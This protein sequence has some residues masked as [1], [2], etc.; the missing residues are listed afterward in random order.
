MPGVVN[1]RR[2]RAVFG[3]NCIPPVRQSSFFKL[4]FSRVNSGLFIFRMLYLYLVRKVSPSS[5]HPPYIY[6]TIFE[7]DY[8]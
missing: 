8:A 3:L 7:P 2:A 5:F 6:N 1:L 4:A